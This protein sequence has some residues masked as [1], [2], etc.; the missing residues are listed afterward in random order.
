MRRRLVAAQWGVGLEVNHQSE[1]VRPVVLNETEDVALLHE[2]GNHK[3][4]SGGTVDI[5]CNKA[6]DIGMADVLPKDSLLAKVLRPA[7]AH[8]LGRIKYGP[9]ISDLVEFD[10]VSILRHA[11]NLNGD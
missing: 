9:V 6:K 7:P 2:F 8:Q 1:A 10:H 4:P 5:D 3:A 11:Q